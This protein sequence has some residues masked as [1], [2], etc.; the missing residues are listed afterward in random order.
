MKIFDIFRRFRK[1]E[2]P[3]ITI[4]RDE[5]LPSDLEKFRIRKG[6]IASPMAPIYE[7][8]GPK[9]YEAP[10]PKTETMPKEEGRYGE[11][12]EREPALPPRP[13]LPEVGLAPKTEEPRREAKADDKLDIVL[14]R[15]EIIDT[16]LKL[17]EERTRK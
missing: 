4:Y 7:E 8:P 14:Q 13:G 5:Q 3:D 10:V 2:E 12:P 15:L 11:V 16:R 6:P 17:I 9:P 1:K